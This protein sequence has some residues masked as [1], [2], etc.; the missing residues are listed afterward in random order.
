MK[1]D[2]VT[3]GDGSTCIMVDVKMIEFQIFDKAV[4]TIIGITKVKKM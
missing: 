3:L 2:V 1:E 4:C